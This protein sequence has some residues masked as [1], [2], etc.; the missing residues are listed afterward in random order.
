MWGPR[1]CPHC[2]GTTKAESGEN[3]VDTELLRDAQAYDPSP[4]LLFKRTFLLPVCK[5]APSSFLLHLP[6]AHE[7]RPRD[8]H[9]WA[10]SAKSQSTA[11]RTCWEDQEGSHYYDKVTF[12]NSRLK[13]KKQKSKCPLSQK[14]CQLN[15]SIIVHFNGN[16]VN[17]NLNS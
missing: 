10:I 6:K 2:P 8:Y 3:R 13:F 1:A 17:R 14:S 7:Y 5:S 4:D 15:F 12:S 11:S 9:P 16:T